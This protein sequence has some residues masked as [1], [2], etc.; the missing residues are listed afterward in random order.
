MDEHGTQEDQPMFRHLSQCQSFH[1]YVSIFA[2]PTSSDSAFV[3]NTKEHIKNA[4]ISNYSIID[5]HNKWSQLSFLEAYYM[6]R[7]S[8][9]INKGLKASK[10]LQ[11]FS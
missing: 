9:A 11:L 10:E 4:V 6:K 5:Y 2:L 1:D 3:L 7:F 8:P